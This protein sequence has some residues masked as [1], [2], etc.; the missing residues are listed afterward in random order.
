[1]VGLFNLGGGEIILILATL[2]ILVAVPAVVV[3]IIFLIIR[4][5]RKHGSSVSPSAPPPIQGSRP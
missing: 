1:M 2:L 5:N 4:M 3:G